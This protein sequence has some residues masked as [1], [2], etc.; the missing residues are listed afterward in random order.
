VQA[1]SAPPTDRWDRHLV[2]VAAMSST[3]RSDGDYA[4]ADPGAVRRRQQRI[5]ARPWSRP[6]QVHGATVVD[7]RRQGDG[8]GVDADALVSRRDDV[9]LAVLT[10]D[11]APVVLASPDGV[12]G[13]AHAGWR[14]LV[15]G[16]LQ[17][18]IDAMG[19]LGATEIHAAIGP[20]IHPGC[21]SF[22]ADDLDRAVALGG[23]DLRGVDAAGG[24]AL[25][26]PAG[27]QAVLV[28]SGAVVDDV[29]PTCTACST[30]HW[31]WRARA[32]QERQA[33]VVWR[34]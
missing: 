4:D 23:P 21:Y 26:L 13:V 32:E 2:G 18:T 24:P 30:D 14:G 16:V 11:C 7:V 28:A 12:I 8:Q 1:S 20:C 29:S 17:A 5:V 6:R 9:A 33:T 19:R 31:S 34:V 25:D 22:S 3:G 10:A 27:V 15:G